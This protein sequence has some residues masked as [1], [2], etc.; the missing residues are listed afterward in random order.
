[1]KKVAE[2]LDAVKCALTVISSSS[3]IPLPLTHVLVDAFKCVICLGIMKPPIAY[4]SCCSKLLGCM[5]CIDRWFK[6]K[7][8]EI[9]LAACPH[10]KTTRGY[11]NVKVLKGLDDL[12]S[13]IDKVLPTDSTASDARSAAGAV[14]SQTSS[15]LVSVP[16]SA[17]GRPLPASQ[18]VQMISDESSQEA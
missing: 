10:C 5:T 4:A 6:S 13:Q 18:R 3:K 9:L 1:M 14:V 12:L 11:S 8:E 15:S 16:S 2:N 17:S 7:R